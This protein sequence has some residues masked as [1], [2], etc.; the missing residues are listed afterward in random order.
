VN[1]IGGDGKGSDSKGSK[2]A[3]EGGAAAG[4]PSNTGAEVLES[5]PK[6][7]AK[8]STA[9]LPFDSAALDVLEGAALKGA[10]PS[11]CAPSIEVVAQVVMEI[12]HQ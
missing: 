6:C 5:A 1:P 7:V 11:T 4:R 9:L 8:P 3:M 12:S 10:A 2:G